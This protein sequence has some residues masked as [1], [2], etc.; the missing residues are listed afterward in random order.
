MTYMEQLLNDI[1]DYVIENFDEREILSYPTLDDFAE[2]LKNLLWDCDSVTGNASGS[3]FFSTAK[4][5]E[6]VLN[7][8]KDVVW[9]MMDFDCLEM[10]GKRI[11]NDEW[12]RLDVT[13]RCY[14]LSQA[15][16]EYLENEWGCYF[17]DRED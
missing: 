9:A 8:I 4:A 1:A 13:A 17:Y 7:N 5:K 10:L 2:E 6:M 11:A 15:I 16:E 14:Y 12:E 3:Y